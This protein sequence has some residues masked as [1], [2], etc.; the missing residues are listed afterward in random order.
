MSGQ[1]GDMLKLMCIFIE[2]ASMALK[3]GIFQSSR[4]KI[5]DAITLT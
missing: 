1:G 3:N 4:H 5:R 2:C